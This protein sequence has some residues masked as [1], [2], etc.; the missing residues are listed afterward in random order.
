MRTYHYERRLH[1]SECDPGGIVFFPNYT[2]WMVEGLNEMLL[3]LGID[4]TAQLDDGN[5]GGLPV[6]QLAMKFFEA[7]ALHT[8]V[9]HEICVDK[10]GGKSLTFTH[11]F[12]RDQTLLVEANETRVWAVHTMGDSPSVQARVVPD[13]VRGL[14]TES[15]L[16]S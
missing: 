5:R 8:M 10:V 12:W 16:D 6:V 3:S 11:R 1:W 2:R 14:L 15:A 9:R 7:P 13:N 4:P